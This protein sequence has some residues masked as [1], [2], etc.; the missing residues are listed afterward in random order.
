MWPNIRRVAYLEGDILVVHLKSGL[1]RGAECT[2]V[3]STNKTDCHKIT[4]ILKVALSIIALS[5]RIQ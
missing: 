5:T 4:E 2:P 3:S 1:K